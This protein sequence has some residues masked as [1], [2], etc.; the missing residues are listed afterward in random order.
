MRS[1][2]L[3]LILNIIL[4]ADVRQ[5]YPNDTLANAKTSIIGG[6]QKNESKS[7]NDSVSISGNN[8]LLDI[9]TLK[10]DSSNF[11]ADSLNGQEEA[12]S[13]REKRK[14][15]LRRKDYNH[16]HQVGTALG[17]ML[18]LTLILSLG[19]NVNPK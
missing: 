3:V 11:V 17:M 19:A 7:Q 5:E 16:R 10:M 8:Q 2:F 1:L 6:D 14:S 12:S 13:K 15:R 9:D 4:F 18:F